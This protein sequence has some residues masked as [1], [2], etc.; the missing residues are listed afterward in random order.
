MKITGNAVIDNDQTLRR[1]H[2]QWS[3]A[4]HRYHALKYRLILSPLELRER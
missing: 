2:D 4:Q 3:Q 1:R